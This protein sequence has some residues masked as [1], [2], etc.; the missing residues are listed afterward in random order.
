MPDSID[1]ATSTYLCPTIFILL[2]GRWRQ[3]APAKVT[4]FLLD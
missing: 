1:Y 3:Q 2:A 4:Q